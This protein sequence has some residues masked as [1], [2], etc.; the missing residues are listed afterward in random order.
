MAASRCPQGGIA[1]GGLWSLI[2]IPKG[3]DIDS[4]SWQIGV[5][6]GA[7]QNAGLRYQTRTATPLAGRFGSPQSTRKQTTVWGG[8]RSTPALRKH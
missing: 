6:S 5:W 2:L 1:I 7:G 8:S 4:I 3:R